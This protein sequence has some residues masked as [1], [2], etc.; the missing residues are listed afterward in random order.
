[1]RARVRKVCV[2]RE[3]LRIQCVRACT[4][5][6]YDLPTCAQAPFAMSRSPDARSA[7]HLPRRI[8]TILLAMSIQRLALVTIRELLTRRWK[9]KKHTHTHTQEEE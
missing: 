9:K 6:F 2:L 3:H 7:R 1:M 4:N 8:A 5:A